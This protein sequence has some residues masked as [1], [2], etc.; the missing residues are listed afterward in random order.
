M[1]AATAP[2]PQAQTQ[3]SPSAKRGKRGGHRGQ[4]G[5]RGGGKSRGRKNSSAAAPAD[6][7]STQPTQNEVAPAPEATDDAVVCWICAEPVKYYSVS[8]CNHRT[9]H[10][11]ALRL[12]ALYKKL[13]CTFCKEPQTTVIFTTSPDAL[14]SSYTPDMIPHKDSKLL[15]YFE[16]T[17]MMEE[18]LILLRFNCPDSQCDYTGTGWGDLKLHV[19]GTHG[20]MM[21]DLCI[22]SKKVFSHEHALYPPNVLPLHLPSMLHRSHKQVTKEPIEGGVHPLCGFCKE[23]FFSDDELYVHMRERH[24]ECFICKRN[25]EQHFDQGHFACSKP[26]C[27]AQKFVVFGSA[28][29]LKAHQVEVHGAEMTSRDKKNTQRVE[30][31][32]EFGD[33]GGGR[34]G[35]RDRDRDREHEP[36]P[37]AQPRAVARRRE[38]FGGHLTSS[39]PAPNG[40]QTPQSSGPSRRASPSPQ[41]S[42]EEVDPVVAQRHAAFIS[43]LQSVAPNPITAV[44]A[45]KAAV[46]G[47]RLNEST[48][49]DLISTIWNVLDR[50][51]DD[52]AGI[53]NAIVDLFE[54]EEKK[55]NLLSSWNSFKIEQRQQ[56][57]DLVP[58]EVGSGYAS[59][60][61]GRVL[62]VKHATATRSSSQSSRQVWDRVAQAAGSSSSRIGSA[63][64]PTPRPPD[65]FSVLATP[66]FRQPQRST[67]WA[68]GSGSSS[69]GSRAPTTVPTPVVQQRAAAKKGPP[70]P[71]LTSAA[72]PGLPSSGNSRMKSLV[73]G[74]Q[75]LRNIL[76]EAVPTVAAWKSSGTASGGS[77]S[78][79]GRTEC[80]EEGEGKAEADLVYSR[81]FSNINRGVVVPPYCIHSG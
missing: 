65:S 44:L 74:N 55:S 48:A 4:G 61:S 72:F 62:N 75:S 13:D 52:T 50:N 32:F 58:Q 54:E 49:R 71:S 45:A 53:V 33:A 26:A 2:Q 56:F 25:E 39:S 67:P 34:R 59:I 69:T 7:V 8:A 80:W 76:G 78:D 30:A 22:R 41:R 6:P 36:P 28:I 38:A 31:E 9:C 70:P 14:F 18:T 42:G 63:P 11:C 35:R 5:H 37:A 20:K 77:T 21:C 73:S 68:S 23:C 47:F 29:D 66:A 57:P 17:D 60:A 24:E 12:R 16:S 1:S 3:T 79:S 81:F 15:I 19:R 40:V 46:R 10:V 64:T 51:L 43:R 27:Q